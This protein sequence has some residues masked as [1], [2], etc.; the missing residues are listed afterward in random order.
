MTGSLYASN[1]ASREWRV[2]PVNFA[3]VEPPCPSKTHIKAFP[4][5][6]ISSFVTVDPAGCVGMSEDDEG[7]EGLVGDLDEAGGR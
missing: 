2:V 3:T 7:E 5:V 4:S 6:S 1:A